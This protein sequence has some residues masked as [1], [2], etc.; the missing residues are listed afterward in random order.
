MVHLK[1]LT[2]LDIAMYFTIFTFKR[3]YQWNIHEF[4]L[5]AVLNFTWFLSDSLL[6]LVSLLGIVNKEQTK[7]RC[8]P[9]SYTTALPLWNIQAQSYVIDKFPVFRYIFILCFL[10]EFRGV[11]LSRLCN[12]DVWY[13]TITLEIYYWSIRGSMDYRRDLFL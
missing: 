11:L 12:L 8:M 1:K 9:S 4:V 6:G 7:S 2:E 5:I 10:F 3:L 13:F